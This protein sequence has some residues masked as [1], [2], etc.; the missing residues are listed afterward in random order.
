MNLA[1][2][3]NGAVA[4]IFQ[5][6][7]TS[8]M[9]SEEAVLKEHIFGLVEPVPNSEM[10][11]NYWRFLKSIAEADRL[12]LGPIEIVLKSRAVARG[13]PVALKNHVMALS[14]EAALSPKSAVV[15]VD[16]TDV[17]TVTFFAAHLVLPLL[18][19]GALARSPFA[20]KMTHQ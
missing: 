1:E 13:W 7:Q 14:S 10:L 3:R 16:I 20:R 12:L 19:D 8:A 5:R 17:S 15:M 18:T 9:G 2:F 4:F 6:P 11:G